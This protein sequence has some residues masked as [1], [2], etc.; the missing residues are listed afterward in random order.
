VAMLL[1]VTNLPGDTT[2]RHGSRRLL[3]AELEGRRLVPPPRLRGRTSQPAL[4][5]RRRRRRGPGRLVA[6]SSVGPSGAPPIDPAPHD[7]PG[8]LCVRHCHDDRLLWVPRAVGP[9]PRARLDVHPSALC[10][11]ERRPGPRITCVSFSV[12]VSSRSRSRSALGL[13]LALLSV[14]LHRSGTRRDGWCER[15]SRGGGPEGRGTQGGTTSGRG[16]HRV[17]PDAGAE[18]DPWVATPTGR[19]T[20]RGASAGPRPPTL[21]IT[22]G[23]ASRY[24]HEGEGVARDDGPR[25]RRAAVGGTRADRWCHPGGR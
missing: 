14:F 23:C 4:V 24:V 7:L 25:A 12:S 20:R 11:I 9:P 13:G 19:P 16:V 1:S 15:R 21:A 3:R 17:S 18:Q 10:L 6:P 5:E 22:R 8:D 2:G